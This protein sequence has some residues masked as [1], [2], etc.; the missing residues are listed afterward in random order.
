CP[1]L[2]AFAIEVL[3]LAE[4]DDLALDDERKEDGVR[5]RQVIGGEDRPSLIGNVLR[6]FVPGVVIDLESRPQQNVLEQAVVHQSSALAS[7]AA[8][9]IPESLPI[10]AAT[11]GTTGR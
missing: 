1:A 7:A 11:I 8:P 2:H 5:E 9:T 4:E 3:G 10:A 6:A